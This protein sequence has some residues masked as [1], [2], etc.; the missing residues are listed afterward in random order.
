MKLGIIVDSSSGMSKKEAEKRG[1]MYLPLYMNI[2]GKE[3]ADGVDISIKEYY[4]DISIESDVQ[5]SATPP[6][7]IIK[8]FEEASKKY[9]ETIVYGIS[10]ELSSQP[11]NLKVFSEEF[12][13]IHVINSKG[14]GYA[15]I[16]DLEMAEEL[17]KKKKGIKEIIQTVE[18]YSSSQFGVAIPGSMKWLVKGGRVSHAAASMANLLRIVPMI[19]FKNGALDKYGKGRVFEKTVLKAAKKL[20]S[21]VG[22][23]REF[24]IYSGKTRKNELKILKEEVGQ[25]VFVAS[26]PPV[27]ANHTGPEVIALMSRKKNKI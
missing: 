15:I 7:T 24:I 1:W 4:K 27:I 18:E 21:E 17:N 26:L 11:D 6:A 16:R 25:D 22:Q 13:N 8:V 14:V 9:D 20:V 12:K 23:E 3:Y 2:D 19:A 10:S 5:T